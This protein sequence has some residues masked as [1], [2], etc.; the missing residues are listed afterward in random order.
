MTTKAGVII[1]A[2]RQRL[3]VS[4]QQSNLGYNVEANRIRRAPNYDHRLV[5]LIVGQ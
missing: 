2:N 1:T 4:Q 3:G 5:K